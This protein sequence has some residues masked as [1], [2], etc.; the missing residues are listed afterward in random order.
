MVLVCFLRVSSHF[1]RGLMAWRLF[2]L[3]ACWLAGARLDWL[4]VGRYLWIGGLATVLLH[5]RR[6]ERSAD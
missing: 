5:A 1:D 6:S 2:G 3:L 4:L